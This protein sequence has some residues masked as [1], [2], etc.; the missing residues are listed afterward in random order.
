M[1]DLFTRYTKELFSKEEFNNWLISKERECH[2]Q[3]VG[4]KREPF[5]CPI[6]T[7]LNETTGVPY[8]VTS[9]YIGTKQAPM[10]FVNDR[11]VRDF[12]QD[13]DRAKTDYDRYCGNRQI[14]AYD[15]LTILNRE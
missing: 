9:E 8:L 13:I 5:Y 1:G 10:Q 3:V 7:F 6:A 4:R 12:V 15:A 11:W 2:N 14:G